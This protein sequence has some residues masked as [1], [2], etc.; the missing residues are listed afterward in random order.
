MHRKQASTVRYVL[1]TLKVGVLEP[2][3]ERDAEQTQVGDSG[4]GS[5]FRLAAKLC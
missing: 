5:A 3:Q 4:R 1:L 2:A